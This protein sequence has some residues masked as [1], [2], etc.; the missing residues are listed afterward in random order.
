MAIP[1]AAVSAAAVSVL[2]AVVSVITDIR[3]NVYIMVLAMALVVRGG[4][5]GCVIF[6]SI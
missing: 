3:M 4:W 5:S 1:A 6:T 2:P